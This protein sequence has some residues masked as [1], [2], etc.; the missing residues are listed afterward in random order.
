MTDETQHELARAAATLTVADYEYLVESGPL[1]ER[2]LS[3]EQDEPDDDT[4][5]EPE[6]DTNTHET[7]TQE[8]EE[9]EDDTDDSDRKRR[10]VE[11]EWPEVGALLRGEHMGTVYEARVIE[12]PQ[13]K[14]GKAVEILTGPAKGE[15]SHSMSGAMLSATEAQ[16]EEAG[17]GRKGVS[18]GWKFWNEVKGGDT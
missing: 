14:S 16:R 11:H 10:K 17:T 7:V 9:Q 12:A 4:E 13:Y 6:P 1:S 8:E 5:E 2:P 18:N 3:Q 15:V